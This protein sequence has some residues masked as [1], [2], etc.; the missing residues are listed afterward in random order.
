VPS[1]LIWNTHTDSWAESARD[2][3][4]FLLYYLPKNPGAN[5]GELPT[6]LER[7]PEGIAQNRRRNGFAGERT[8]VGLGHSAGMSAM[9]VISMTHVDVIISFHFIS[10][11]SNR[12]LSALWEPNLYHSLC[13]VEPIVMQIEVNDA[14]I[15]D[16]WV[17]GAIGRRATW[18][19]R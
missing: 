6:H 7:L 12:F 4:H 9:S 5:G 14:P 15:F 13:A 11:G 3:I 19:S 16:Q 18:S 10:I 1:G 17:K 2:L 8:L